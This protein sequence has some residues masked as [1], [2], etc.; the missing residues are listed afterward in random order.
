MTTQSYS[1]TT[2]DG[3]AGP[4]AIPT[5]LLIGEAWVPAASGKR[6]DILNPATDAVLTSVADA[7]PA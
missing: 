3:H 2:T 6:I 1:C 5:D 7:S 4:F